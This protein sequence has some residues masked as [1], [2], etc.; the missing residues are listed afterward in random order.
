[1]PADLHRNLIPERVMLDL[2]G[3]RLAFGAMALACAS[4][5]GVGYYLQFVDGLEPC[6]MCILQ[7][8]CYMVV[9]LLA[10]VAAAHGPARVGQRVYSALLALPVLI[11]LGV[12]ARQTWLQH[13]PEDQV[14]ECGPGLTFM[15][16][17]Y[18]PF[19]VLKRTLRGTGDCAKVDWTLLGLSIAEW[20][21]ICFSSLL[22]VLLL[23]FLR[24]HDRAPRA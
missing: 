4:L 12:A 15:L 14:P 2:L 20:S 18:A 8:V 16:Q 9:T 5:L 17:M 7:R 1:M 6:P 19:E 13:L 11:G 3:T 24:A 23:Q 22:I 10:V 21:V